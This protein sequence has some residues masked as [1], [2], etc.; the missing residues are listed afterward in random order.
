MRRDI[1]I[2]A[3]WGLALM[4]LT[5]TA[6]GLPPVTPSTANL[7][8]DS[9]VQPGVVCEAC[10]QAT[11]AGAL[12][13]ENSNANNQAVATAEIVRANA[14]STLSVAQTQ[15]QNESN[16]IAAQLASTAEIE[17]AN[18][19]ATLNSAVFTQSAALTQ[20]AIRQT[21]MADLATTGAEAIV[22][23][24]NNNQ[25]AGST[26]TA[27][28]NTIA[29]QARQDETQRRA[30]ITFLWI[31]CLPVFVV[32]LAGLFLWG[33]WRRLKIQQANQRI[34]VNPSDQLPAR[35]TEVVDRQHGDS[36][37]YLDTDVVDSG[38]Q[39]TTP[40]DQVHQWLDEVKDTLRDSDK[41]DEDNDADGRS[42]PL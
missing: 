11:L 42:T 37:S 29:T 18:A 36:M 34:L 17:R 1:H 27:V 2:K 39:V 22:V 32:I 6:C 5:L 25:L 38:Y 30:P 24:Q 31:W 20:D 7:L 40:D 41:K 28:A 14:Q 13:Q 10:D 33:Y 4:L 16:V 21:Q 3:I 15:D 8:P 12:T 23:Q 9:Q 19:Q 35:V 26:Q